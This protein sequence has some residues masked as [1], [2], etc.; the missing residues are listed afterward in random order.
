MA[1]KMCYLSLFG[2]KKS[3]NINKV[4]SQLEEYRD[5]LSGK[6][7]LFKERLIE[8]GIDTA[9]SNC[10]EYAGYIVFEPKNLDGDISYLIA[11]DGEKIIREWKYKGGVK[12]ATVSPLLMAEFGS[13]F[14]AKVLDDVPG[15]GQGT[16]PGQK[17]AFDAKGWWW[18][19]PD[20]VKHHS[21]SEAPTFP[22]HSASMAMLFEADR[23]AKEV[24]K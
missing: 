18:E 15:V 2:G 14:L 22:M 7:K 12:T 16:F 1:K 19:T 5:S 3:A 11:F 9:K 20:G 6:A 23:I 10:G 17:H 24:F 21:Y 8:A 4:I 13:G